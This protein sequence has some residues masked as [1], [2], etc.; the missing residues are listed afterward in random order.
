MGEVME[1]K[2]IAQTINVRINIGNYQHIELSK[3]AEKEISYEDNE[4][5]TSQEDEL[6]AE[7]MDSLSRDM[8][9]IPSKFKVSEAVVEETKE[10]IGK[11]LPDWMKGNEEPNL[12]KQSNIKVEAEEKANQ[13]EIKAKEEVADD[14]ADALLGEAET[15]EET[16][17]EAKPEPEETK[18]NDDD[19]LFDEDDLF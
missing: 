11:A 19:E 3:Y 16:K 6:T 1:T 9:I 14:E 15:K 5:M 7:L 13:D 4:G 18:S 8:G 17:E 2:K 12:A 10:S